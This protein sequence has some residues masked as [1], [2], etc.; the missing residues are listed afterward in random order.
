MHIIIYFIILAL[1]VGNDEAFV[2]VQDNCSCEVQ[3]D[4]IYVTNNGD[5]G[6]GTLRC[7]LECASLTG[8]REIIGFDLPEGMDS[9]I[10]LNSPLP[11]IPSNTWIIN[12][13]GQIF[14]DGGQLTN[15]GEYGLRIEGD[16]IIIRGLHIRNFP[17]NAID[18]YLGHDYIVVQNN[19]IYNNGRLT[20]SGDGIDF[21]SAE[22]CFIEDNSIFSNEKDGISLQGCANV[23][24]TGNKISNNQS[25]GINIFNGHFVDIGSIC[26]DCENTITG[27]HEN[28]IKASFNSSNINIVKNYIGILPTQV[29][30]IPN[31]QNGI[32]LS[33]CDTIQ[34][35]N[36][37][38]GNYISGNL[39][40]GIKMVDS[41]NMVAIQNNSIGYSIVEELGMPNGLSGIE[42]LH[43]F[44]VEI[45]GDSA[46]LGNRIGY[47]QNHINIADS[48]NYCS[49]LHN[50]FFC[51][52]NGISIEVGSNEDLAP[53]ND[54]DILGSNAIGG[55]SEIPLHLQLYLRNP[56]CNPCQGNTLL[57]SF[58]AGTG[59]WIYEFDHILNEGDEIALLVTDTLGISSTFSECKSFS[60][61]DYS[62]SIIP[63][64]QDHICMNSTLVLR[65]DTGVLFEWSTGETSQE[66]EIEEGGTYSV[67][68]W[69]AFNCPSSDTIYIP[70]YASPALSLQ[71]ADSTVFCEESMLI[72]AFG[73]GN[74]TWNTGQSGPLILVDS[75]GYYCVSLTNQYNCITE[76]C[77]AVTKGEPVHADI[78]LVG[79]SVICEGESS[80]LIA[81]GGTEYLWSNSHESSE[82]TVTE[83]GNYSVTVTNEY[84]CVGSD[85]FDMTVLPG[86]NASILPAGYIIICPGDS[87]WLTAFG[88]NHY[89]WNDGTESDSLLV[90]GW[91]EYSVTVTN[92]YGCNDIASKSISVKPEVDARIA[93]E[94]PVVVCKPDSVWLT[95]DYNIVDSVLWN[96]G[97]K[98]DSLL[99]EKSGV[100]WAQ[101]FNLGCSVVDSINVLVFSGPDNID[102]IIGPSWSNPDSIQVF[103]LFNPNPN[104]EYLWEV[105]GG[106]ILST[107]SLSAEIQWIRDDFGS[108]CVMA[109]DSNGCLSEP[110][111]RTIDLA[112][113]NIQQWGVENILLYPNP[114][115]GTLNI[116]SSTKLTST[117]HFS[118]EFYNPAGVLIS[119]QSF[120]LGPE[121]SLEKLDV[122]NLPS[123]I[124]WV[125]ISSGNKLL[126]FEKIL[127]NDK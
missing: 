109:I 91:G 100:Y 2:Q 123:G 67:T 17:N 26:K 68:V 105:D 115:S 98:A 30:A 46:V 71:P 37:N 125:K 77:I 54:F 61:E 9:V 108:I 27:N 94:D 47:Q 107:T 127:L 45:G 42:I 120:D 119:K 76:Q 3:S 39:L 33:N 114:A 116:Q 69:N 112:P 89:L 82:L 15:D 60:C 6:D 48:S 70:T 80:T 122:T 4:T 28:G 106:L 35:G 81:T 87:L 5:W 53:F 40:S 126:S 10:T 79:D 58:E 62:V 96:T 65:A 31:H 23:T 88:G 85:S 34:I 41:T 73:Q 22:Y 86:T 11:V 92:E 18:N 63:Q 101:I 99:I 72:S 56:L 57:G 97:V 74:F 111:C 90:K 36:Q 78:Q 102:S 24:I 121:T 12:N 8:G 16:S 32:Y 118:L 52:I 21:R 117:Q 66:I 29:Q 43:S 20:S 83:S 110:Y 1:S 64:G 55:T 49:I 14:L 44:N 124:Y 75:T 95:I 7:A 113:L 104:L 59:D 51:S 50:D 103:E 38:S 25:N 84:G 13:G 19:H 93:N